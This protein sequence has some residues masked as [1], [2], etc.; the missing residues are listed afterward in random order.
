MHL[1]ALRAQIRL[2][3]QA[4]DLLDDKRTQ[5]MEEFRR[6]SEVALAGSDELEAAAAEAVR[7]LRMA[8]ALKGPEAVASV[9]LAAS[10]EIFLQMEMVTIAGVRVPR[11]EQV[12]VGR[13]IVGRGYGLSST[14]ALTDAVADRYE[15]E[16]ELILHVAE[17][18]LRLRRLAAEIGATTRRVNALDQLF[19]P[20]LER[21]L[22]EIRSALDEREREDHFRLRRVKGLLVRRTG[23]GGGAP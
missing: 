1:L 23:D 2:A 12:A 10:G 14:D 16:L 21:R 22:R 13:P 11:I 18:E 4:R 6:A 20:G 3:R 19:I 8:E 9:A 7:A 17:D 15:A 5:L